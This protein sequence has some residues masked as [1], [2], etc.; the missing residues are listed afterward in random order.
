M[1]VIVEA[2]NLVT[3]VP[4]SGTVDVQGIP[5]SIR[6]L[7]ASQVQHTLRV[8]VFSSRFHHSLDLTQ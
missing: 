8:S 3:S 6:R 4:S 1:T 2:S 5:Q 7:Q